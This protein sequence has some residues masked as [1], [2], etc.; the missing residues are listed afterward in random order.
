MNLYEIALPIR[1]NSGRE[2][3][4]ARLNWEAEALLIAGG[5]SQ[6]APTTGFWKDDTGKVHR[7]VCLRYQIACDSVMWRTLVKHAFRLF[8]DQLAIY[9]ARIGEATIEERFNG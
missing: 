6:F 8:P 2:T 4:K 3:T 9:H 5:Y 1:D 7:D